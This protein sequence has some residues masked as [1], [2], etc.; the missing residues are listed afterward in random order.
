VKRFALSVNGVERAVDVQA[1]GASFM[2]RPSARSAS[3]TTSHGCSAMERVEL[4]RARRGWP[5][6]EVSVVAVVVG[7][8]AP[9][10]L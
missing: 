6:H 10:L 3:A 5:I 2:R 7:D 9:Y 1:D 4:E 8:G